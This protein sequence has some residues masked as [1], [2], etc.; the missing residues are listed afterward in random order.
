MYN[1]G[2]QRVIP[3]DLFNESKLLKCIGQVSL[4]IHDGIDKAGNRTPEGLT[5]N[6]EGDAFSIALHDDGYLI[7]LNVSIEYLEESLTLG[8]IYNSKEPYPLYDIVTGTQVLTDSGTWHQDF[9][10]LLSGIVPLN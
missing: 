3:R 7:L 1:Q 8:T 5:I 6:Q 10:N 2:Y 9:L 4:L